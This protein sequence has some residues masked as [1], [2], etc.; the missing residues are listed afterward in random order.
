MKH[1]SKFLILFCCLIATS[2]LAQSP[3]A[4]SY[5]A[6]ARTMDGNALSNASLIVKMGIVANSMDGNLMWEEEHAVSTDDVGLFALSIGTGTSTGNGLS[7]SFAQ[8]NWGV[9]SYFLSV[10]ID[11]GTG[12]ELLGVSQLLSVPY[13]L[14]A[15]NAN[16]LDELIEDFT[17]ENDSL[18][19]TEAGEEHVLDIGPMLDEA[20]NGESINLVQ[21]V[22]TDLNIVEGDDAFVVDLSSLQEDGDWEVTDDAVYSN[23]VNVGIDTPSPTSSLSVNGSISFKVEQLQGPINADL[24]I[25][26]NIILANVSN[27]DITLNLPDA[28]MCPGRL[29]KIKRFGNEP[30]SSNVT[31]LPL[32]GQSIEGDPEEVLSGFD[33][34]VVEI[35]SDGSNWWIMSKMTIE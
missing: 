31:L 9:T 5:Q 26:S 30:L 24:T 12:F 7:P 17:F 23:G 27:G 1:L 22:G 29:Y 6:V 20:L 19:I 3:Q 10:E 33:G 15:E 35:I 25:S 13:A 34:Q 4:I 11:E 28:S 14:Y 18:I 8:I 21:L 16:P 32:L 2:A